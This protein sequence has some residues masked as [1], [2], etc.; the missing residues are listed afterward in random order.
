M[1]SWNDAKNNKTILDRN[2][3]YFHILSSIT[4]QDSLMIFSENVGIFTLVEI[5]MR[6]ESD[7]RLCTPWIQL[8]TF[9]STPLNWSQYLLHY[10]CQTNRQIIAA[11]N[12]GSTLSASCVKGILRINTT[13][14]TLFEA[15]DD[16]VREKSQ[17][18]GRSTRLWRR[19]PG[20]SE[21]RCK[22]RRRHRVSLYRSKYQGIVPFLYSTARQ[23]D[24]FQTWETQFNYRLLGDRKVG[25]RS[26]CCWFPFLWQIFR[27]IIR[28]KSSKRNRCNLHFK[29][30]VRLCKQTLNPQQDSKLIRLEWFL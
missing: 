14:A 29:L 4:S 24:Y 27:G 6:S 11:T 1:K 9:K 12:Q 3:S 16:T 5:C 22:R 30:F 20:W 13:I 17:Q 23:L 21:K 26:S 25:E 10:A 7:S 18:H 2:I 8:T 28:L 15:W 19:G